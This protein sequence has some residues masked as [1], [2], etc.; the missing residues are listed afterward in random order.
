MLAPA[1]IF[2]EY[3][4]PAASR[5]DATG[6]RFGNSSIQTAT[7]AAPTC[8]QQRNCRGQHDQYQ[9]ARNLQSEKSGAHRD[10]RKKLEH[11][12]HPGTVSLKVTLVKSACSALPVRNAGVWADFVGI[13]R[14]LSSSR[15]IDWRKKSS[16][17][18]LFGRRS[19]LAVGRPF[20]FT[21]FLSNSTGSLHL[22]AA[23]RKLI[24]PCLAVMAK[25]QQLRDT[26]C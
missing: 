17:S 2:A 15:P 25:S 13:K 5:S 19:P 3:L 23:D 6:G 9:R 22:A 20:A 1:I 7:F 10:L 24:T 26:V 21:S 12:P 8:S 4:Y 16:S 11:P 18:H 14:R